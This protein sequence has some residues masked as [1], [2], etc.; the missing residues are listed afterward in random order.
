MAPESLDLGKD[1]PEILKPTSPPSPSSSSSPPSNLTASQAASQSS[2]QLSPAFFPSKPS[3]DLCAAPAVKPSA[4][5]NP[6]GLRTQVGNRC[7]TCRK[8][9]GLTGFRC[10]CGDLFC[11]RHRYSDAHHCSFDY[12]AAGREE[13]SKA[14]PLIRPAKIIKI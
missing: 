2:T 9:V 7:S 11:A 13:I 5:P 1:E 12:K 6:A 10:R 4:L 3:Q 14:N 8:R